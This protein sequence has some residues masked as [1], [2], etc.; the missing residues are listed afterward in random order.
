MPPTIFLYCIATLLFLHPL[1]ASSPPL[2]S[3]FHTKSCPQLPQIVRST[4]RTAFEN[5]SRVAS[6]ILELQF[7][8]CFVNGCD[9]SILLDDQN[10]FTGEKNP[11]RSLNS[12]RAFDLVDRIKLRLEKACPETVSCADIVS[13]ATRDAVALASG[14]SWSVLLGR[15]DGQSASGPTA[16]EQLASPFESLVSFTNKF[17]SKGLNASDVVA[18]LGSHT[19]GFAQCRTF[20]RR[21]VDYKGTGKPDSS[22]NPKLL[23]KLKAAC[24]DASTDSQ[25]YPLNPASPAYFDNSYYQNLLVNNGILES[26]QVLMTDQLTASLV[27]EFSK[28]SKLFFK[29]FAAS[30]IKLGNVGVITAPNG[31]IRKNCR[32]VNVK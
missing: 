22:L 28:D 14:P 7:Q 5:D 2:H 21:L 19:I 12:W 32:L 29:A 6:V 25:V 13:L 11:I 15:R 3:D 16:D 17:R 26:D 8:D 1:T 20:R 30:M 31:E 27:V 18:L 9:G 23:Q 10:G 24:P 4:V